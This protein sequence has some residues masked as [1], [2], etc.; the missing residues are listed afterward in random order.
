[1]LIDRRTFQTFEWRLAASAALLAALSV[2]VIYS[3]SGAHASLIRRSLYL[4]QATWVLVGLSAMILLCSLHYRTIARL[5]SI[6]T[7]TLAALV[8]VALIGRS[9][10]GAQRWLTLGPLV[11]QPSEFMKL[12]LIVLLARYLEDHKEEL[13]APRIFFLPIV[14]TLVPAALVLRQP[15]LGTAL[16]LLFTSIS[17]MLV[18]GL[19]IRYFLYIGGTALAIAPSSGASCATTRRIASLSSSIPARIRWE[20]GII[21]PNP[22]SPSDPGD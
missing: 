7:V 5:A 19:K 6:Y 10:F 20:R 16:V 14:L 13:G 21:S 3:T 9:G 18:V 12:S 2:V 11:F 8:L 22:R 4:K 1:M 17:V 15:D